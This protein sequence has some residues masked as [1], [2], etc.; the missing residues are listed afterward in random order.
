MQHSNLIKKDNVL[1]EWIPTTAERSTPGSEN[2]AK[3]Q[4]QN[5]MVA[6]AKSKF[7]S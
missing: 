7:P 2:K 1:N 4:K 3:A 6:L 5:K